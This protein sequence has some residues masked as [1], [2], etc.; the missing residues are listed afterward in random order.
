M[1]RARTTFKN[2]KLF[3]IPYSRQSISQHDI[4]EVVKAL[5]DDFLTGGKRVKEFEDELCKYLDVKYS[6]VLNSATSALHVAF[7]CAN[8]QQNDEFITTPITFAATSNAGMM[9]GAKPIFCDIKRNGNIDEKKI[10]SLI[11]KK[12]K[13]IVPV[14]F[15]GLPVNIDEI[16]KIAKKHNLIVI[17]D[18]SHAL[19]SRYEDGTCVGTKADISIFSFH[20]IKPITTFEGGALVTNDK[21]IYKRALLLRSHH[22]EKRGLWDWSMDSIGYNYRLSDVAC[23]LGISQLKRLDQFIKQRDK[24]ALFYDKTFKD[25]HFFTTIQIPKNITSSR[26]LY[27]IFLKKK[28]LSKKKEIFKA[29]QK[30]GLGVQV[31]YKPLYKSKLYRSFIDKPLKISEHFYKSELSIPCHQKMNLKDAKFVAK[32]LLEVLSS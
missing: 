27:P 24:I 15:G 4:K 30:R 17:D 6:V 16:L 13:A 7:M 26:H 32:N 28:F 19:G 18:A 5:K 3:M 29:L 9:V 22:I 10:Q 8:L 21:N 11:N 31:H 2:G 12:T 23:S 20:A 14:D 1:V 25:N